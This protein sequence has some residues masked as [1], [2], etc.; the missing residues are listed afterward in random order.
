MVDIVNALVTVSGASARARSSAAR[1]RRW[2]VSR[3]SKHTFSISYVHWTWRTSGR[4]LDKHCKNATGSTTTSVGLR[5]HFGW[6]LACSL[7]RCNSANISNVPGASVAPKPVSLTICGP[8]FTLLHARRFCSA[9]W[10]ESLLRLTPILLLQSTGKVLPTNLPLTPRELVG[11]LQQLNS[12]DTANPF[13]FVQQHCRN[14]A[15]RFPSSLFSNPVANQLRATPLLQC[16][17]NC[18]ETVPA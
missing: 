16:L 13:W 11:P 18:G 8:A 10:V 6:D 15:E 5:H 14:E 3:S 9:S 4:A 17:S 1:K 7:R 12:T 2:R